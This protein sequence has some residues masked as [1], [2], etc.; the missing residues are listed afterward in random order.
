MKAMPKNEIPYESEETYFK[1]AIKFLA[2]YG[3]KLLTKIVEKRRKQ[4]GDHQLEVDHELLTLHLDQGMW[5]ILPDYLTSKENNFE[6][7]KKLD[8]SMAEDRFNTID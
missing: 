7:F 1:L 8:L 3:S 6:A 2:L 4:E 5:S